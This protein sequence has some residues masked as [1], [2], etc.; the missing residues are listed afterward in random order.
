MKPA[1]PSI[2]HVAVICTI[3]C[4]VF[5]AGKSERSRQATPG[6]S[7]ATAPPPVQILTPN[8]GVDFT[9]YTNQMLASI[10]R[11][12]YAQMPREAYAGTKGKVVV[13]FKIQQNG[14]LARTPMIEANSGNQQYDKAAVSAVRASAPFEHLPVAFKGPNIELRMYFLY[15]MPASALTP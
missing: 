14:K 4:T 5:A 15:N 13:R 9:P 3:A 6:P 8:E 2:L 11:S 7:S 12:W 10:R 1:R